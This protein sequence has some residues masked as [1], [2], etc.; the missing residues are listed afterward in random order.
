MI[1]YHFNELTPMEK[2]V[3][4]EPSQGIIFFGTQQ[5]LA[6]VRLSLIAGTDI[7]ISRT[8]RLSSGPHLK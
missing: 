3:E 5:E 1:R 2:F 7:I 6:I 8:G 4:E